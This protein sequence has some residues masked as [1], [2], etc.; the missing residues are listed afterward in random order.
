MSRLLIV[1]ALLLCSIASPALAADIQESTETFGPFG[2][3]HIYRTSAQPAHMTLFVSGDGGWNL[4]VIDMARSL[5][6]L[7]SMVVGID[8]THYIKELNAGNEK[9]AYSAAHFE[10]L[11]QY[12]QKKYRFPHYTLP[13]LV[14]YSSGATLVYATLAQ[15]PPNTFAG[16][17]SMGF[18]PDL[19]TAKPLCKGNGKLGS[20]H[21][22][23]LGYV[24]DPVPALAA[25]LHVLQG[26]IDQVCS[27]PDTKTFLSGIGGAEMIELPKVGH[28]FS[29]QRNWMPQFKQAFRKLTE[30]SV[31]ANTPV[32]EN[33]PDKLSDLP[34]VE[35]P[36][37]GRNNT[38]AVMVSGDGGWAGIDKQ[39]A[40]ALNKDGIAVVG[41]NSL[42]YFWE[43]KDPDIAGRDL[44]RILEHYGKAWGADRFILIGYSTGAD[45]LP[46]MVSRLP[47]ALR[48]RVHVVALLGLAQE[49]NFEFHVSDWLFSSAGT[50]KVIPEIRKL[51]GL[52]VLCIYGEDEND[53]A[54]KLLTRNDATAV[55]MKGGHHFAG[56]YARVAN[57]ILSHSR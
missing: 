24:Y 49:A 14:G 23:R 9:C 28:G 44:A 39:I 36:A 51:G 42:Q 50:Y 1:A 48:S 38:L 56:E 22:P 46:F 25:P 27:T 3:V 15:S 21:D 54:C 40:E 30:T 55:E 57:T 6:E 29:V 33:I 17:I 43:K 11:S 37:T 53:S 16:G 41:L 2:T 31:P 12:L 19:M 34:L 32:S 52:N 5:A 8:I 4:G 47:Q 10:A 7:D 26:D 13:V 45:T 35:L 20:K 18:C